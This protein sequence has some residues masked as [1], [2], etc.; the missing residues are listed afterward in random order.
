MNAAIACLLGLTLLLA[1]ILA[2][3]PDEPVWSSWLSAGAFLAALLA[4]LA[5][6][7]GGRAGWLRPSR[8]E[9]AFLVLLG[10]AF[11]SMPVRMAVQHGTGF[12]GPMLRGWALLAANFALFALARRVASER[13]WLYGLA[14]AAVVGAAIAADVGVREYVPHFL[15]ELR[16]V[17]GEG[18]Y[19]VFGTSTPDYL[20]GYFVLL[21]P[22]TLALFLQA[23]S[24]PGLTP[25]LRTS[26]AV[27]LGIVLLFQLVALLTTGSR[28]GLASFAVSLVVFG[29]SLVWTT[30]C[31][32][33]LSTATR[34]LLA[35]IGAL[36]VL[37]GSIAAKPVLNRL[38]NLHDNSIAFRVWTWKGSV[39]MAVANPV[40]GT[41]IGTWPDLY[42]RYAETGFTRVAHESYL[43][44]ADECGIPALLALLATLGLLGVSLA[45]GLAAAPTVEEP[46]PLPPPMP[47]SRKAQRQTAPVPSALHKTNYLPTDNRLLLCGLI[48][49][50]AGGVVQNL[51][52]SDWYVFFLGTTFWTLAGL[53][54]GI[55]L[56][57]SATEEGR[58]PKPTLIALGSV[59]AAFCALMATEGVAANYAAQAQ[60]NTGVDPAGAARTYDAAR[61][62]DP[63]NGHYP[64]DEG[65]KV[66]YVRGGDLRQ[67]ESSVRTAIALVPNSV[68]YRRL[69]TILQA[70]GRQAE[71]LQAYQEGLKA[72]PDSLDILNDLARLT[73][74]PGRLDYYRRLSELELT[75]V[76][77]VRALGEMT[78]TKFARAD[79]VMGEEAAKTDPA[80]AIA[81][82]GRAAA[83]LEKYA[84]E[85]GS[86]NE[87]RVASENGHVN[88]SQDVDMG[89]LYK[90]VLDDWIPIAPPDQ[91]QILRQR[92][93]KYLA[94]FAEL[95]ARS[96]KSGNI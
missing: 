23:P 53:A 41:G 58:P 76:G 61:A 15:A 79:I 11:L 24:A 63:L 81:Y 5:S 96:S 46:D 93:Q 47:Q 66:Y 31:G 12:F 73:P 40:L 20:A 72:E 29:V 68:N 71:A 35:V 77:T 18:S 25:L 94:E 91:Q 14:F 86:L 74:L 90:R 83:T 60:A 78:E 87:Q 84:D 54:A 55:A 38:H 69:G 44:L 65:Y 70:G 39:N 30:R 22:V 13:V 27:V 10:L 4:V 45:R 92:R 95:F 43:Q 42:P 36:V 17:K 75:P 52:D 67:A 16:G 8:T 88:P 64:S 26:A 89:G 21:L 33:H 28:F 48:A 85:G 6:W 9:Q 59:A 57:V 49:A 82:Y 34:V 7:K 1:P 37:T 2:A 3:V 62:W 32:L 50:L 80:Q 19:R 56:P 51:I